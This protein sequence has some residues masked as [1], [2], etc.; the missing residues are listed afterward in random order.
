MLSRKWVVTTKK[1]LVEFVTVSISVVN[2]TNFTSFKVFVRM[3]FVVS[4]LFSTNCVTYNLEPNIGVSF[5]LLNK[6]LHIFT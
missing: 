4:Y 6:L 2:E 5:Q 3:A 1:L